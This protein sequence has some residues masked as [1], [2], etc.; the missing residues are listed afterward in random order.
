MPQKKSPQKKQGA[1]SFLQTNFLYVLKVFRLRWINKRKN[2]INLHCKQNKIKQ[3]QC[4][5]Y[6]PQWWVGCLLTDSGLQVNLFQKHSFLNQ[7]THNM[8]TDC[9]LLS[10]ELFNS[11]ER[12]TVYFPMHYPFSTK[13][14]LLPY[15]REY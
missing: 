3:D 15:S 1:D 8:T 10:S 12:A 13:I 6:V 5:N 14:A 7:L 2:S 11:K 4:D 9:S